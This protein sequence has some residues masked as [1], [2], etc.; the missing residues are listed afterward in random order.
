M[1]ELPISQSSLAAEDLYQKLWSSW[2]S[3]PCTK[4]SDNS[5]AF[6]AAISY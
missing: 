5:P 2:G 3:A 4:I 6:D 1:I